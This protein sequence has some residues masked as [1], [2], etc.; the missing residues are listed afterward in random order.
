MFQSFEAKTKPETAADRIAAIR[1]EM[2]KEKLDAFLIPRGDAH[3]GEYVAARDERLLWATSFTG[4]AGFAAV[5]CET[6]GLFVDGRYTLQAQSETDNTLFTYLNIPDDALGAW[7]Q[8]QLF[9]GAVIGYDPWLYTQS[10]IQKLQKQAPA[11]KQLAVDNLVDRVWADQPGPPLDK[12][13]PYPVDLAGQASD[14]KRKLLA[15]SL[16]T[17]DQSA[18]VITQPDSIAW[19][20]NTRG[21]D[22]GQTPVALAFAVLHADASLDLYLPPAKTDQALLD[23]LGLQ[24]RVHDPSKF[25]DG[26]RGLTGN[27]LMDK[28]RAPSILADWLGE[29][30]VFGDDPCLAPKA[31]KNDA[32][33][34]GAKAAHLRDGLA[35]TRFLHHVATLKELPSEIDLVKKLE[36]CRCETGALKNISFDTICGSGPNGAIVHYRVTEETNRQL[37]WGDVLLVDSGG[38]YLDGTT[39]I[40]R[41][42]AIGDV[43]LEAREAFTLVLKGMIA[44]S[45]ARFP[46]GLAGRDI[47]ALARA[48]LWA[49]GMDYDH[50]TGHGVGAYLGVHEGPQNLSR[51]SHVP[52]KLGMILSNEPGYYR[53]GAFGIRIENLIYVVDAPKGADNRDMYAFETLTLAPIDRAMIVRGLLSAAER[54]WLDAY[55]ARVFESLSPDLPSDVQAWLADATAPL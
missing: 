50:G 14:E 24:I 21:V 5:I 1:A 18:V 35:V 47:D 20:T 44:I 7:L 48:P 29:K 6:V 34:A 42:I 32:E 30:A 27:V 31:Q 40:T 26:V 9:E 45:M 15:A 52:L 25:E 55:H 3:Q 43:P 10:Q 49:H 23:H 33:I 12:M 36:A 38:Q 2:A 39:D 4:S 28:A 16:V 19:L 13:Q 51:R 53:E 22:L 11:L 8:D 54:A 37:E 46:K 17:N 41:T